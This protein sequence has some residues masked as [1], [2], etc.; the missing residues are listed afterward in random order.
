MF[1]GLIVKAVK[2]MVVDP[3]MNPN[4]PEEAEAPGPAGQTSTR[5]SE[6]DPEQFDRPSGDSTRFD[7]DSFDQHPAAA[8]QTTLASQVA[9]ASSPDEA[10]ALMEDAWGIDLPYFPGEG[11]S[12]GSTCD[13]LWVIDREYAPDAGCDGLFATWK[14]GARCAGCGDC[15]E[16][17]NQWTHVFVRPA[18]G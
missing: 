17:A 9:S 13:C 18:A 1:K 8:G 12:C 7:P 11:T 6:F 15:G 16:R 4:Q 2:D 3:I 10:R 5:Q 14:I